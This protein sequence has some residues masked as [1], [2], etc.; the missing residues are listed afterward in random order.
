[1]GLGKEG[2]EG[3]G[4]CLAEL[5]GVREDG[6]GCLVED[7]VHARLPYK[8]SERLKKGEFWMR[9]LAAEVVEVNGTS[10]FVVKIWQTVVDGKVEAGPVWVRFS[11]FK[12]E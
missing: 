8:K 7:D 1:M 2:E 4:S 3:F 12:H 5:I 11:L 9:G 10:E 6:Y